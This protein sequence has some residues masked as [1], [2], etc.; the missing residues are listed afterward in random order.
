MNR[1]IKFRAWHN[2]ANKMLKSG[3]NRQIFS[4]QDEGQDITI[5][6]FTGLKDRNGVEIYEGDILKTDLCHPSWVGL[7]YEIVFQEGAFQ[8]KTKGR[9]GSIAFAYHIH[10]AIINDAIEN[11][12]DYD[13]HLE[14]IGNIYEHP[15]LL[16]NQ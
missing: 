9:K 10:T 3:T 8:M 4:W 16:N 7:T 11:E 2:R 1:L 6:Q 14:I 15:H 5:M 12:S 13:K